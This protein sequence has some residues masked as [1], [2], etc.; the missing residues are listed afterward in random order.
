[1]LT[2][3]ADMNASNDRPPLVPE[4]PV[5]DFID[6]YWLKQE[7][8]DFCRLHGL[9]A[10]GGKQAITRRIAHWLQTGGP[11]RE[12]SAPKGLG[13]R[14]TTPLLLALDAP[15]TTAYA[16]SQAVRA[17]FTAQIGPHFRFSVGLMRFCRENPDKTFGEAVAYWQ[18]EHERKGD[19]A[20]QSEIAPQFEY[21]QYI[22]DFKQNNPGA[23]LKEA[24]RAWQ[25]KRSQRGP[26][27]YSDQD[28][29]VD[30][31]SQP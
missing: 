4:M 12:S 2:P 31:G 6:Y 30:P 24:I 23:S 18:K 17:F 14:A 1:M 22:R 11:P 28:L 26:N 5:A 20:Y 10:T 3:F 16:S 27:R 29:T 7:L 25:K 9:K 21:N 13:E 15:I 19:P 8:I